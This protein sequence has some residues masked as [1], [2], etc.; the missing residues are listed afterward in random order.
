MGFNSAFKGLIRGTWLYTA[1]VWATN[2]KTLEQYQIEH[3][4]LD[5]TVRELNCRSIQLDSRPGH[6]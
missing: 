3:V 1:A 2:W 5:G 6:L 4:G